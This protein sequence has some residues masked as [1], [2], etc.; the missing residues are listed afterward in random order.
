MDELKAALL[1]QRRQRCQ[2]GG[3]DLLMRPSA[4]CGALDALGQV[5]PTD[6]HRTGRQC[7]KS[8]SNSKS[9]ANTFNCRLSGC[10]VPSSHERIKAVA[11]PIFAATWPGVRFFSCRLTCIQSPIVCML[12][13]NSLDCC[14]VL[15]F[16]AY[17]MR[18]CR[19]AIPNRATLLQE[20]ENHSPSL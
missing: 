11:I 9:F 10:V 15:D 6:R 2:P 4:G 17:F 7:A 14:C 16:W 3:A 8:A 5:R 20:R 12:A 1:E 18:I 19:C 13:G